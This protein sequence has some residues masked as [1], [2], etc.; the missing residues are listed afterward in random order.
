MRGTITRCGRCG[1][2]L[3]KKARYGY[4]GRMPIDI[5]FC[6]PL[7]HEREFAE[8]HN[9]RELMAPGGKFVQRE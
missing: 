6:T 1:S 9:P 7:R 2:G 4:F 5:C 3:E 8:I